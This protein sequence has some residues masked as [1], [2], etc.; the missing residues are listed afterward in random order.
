MEKYDPQKI[1]PKWSRHMGG[2]SPAVAGSTA[3][4]NKY[5]PKIIERKWQDIWEKSGIYKT[6]DFSEKSKFY[7]LDF[8]PYPSGD[9]LHVGHTKGYIATDA[10]SRMKMMQGFNVLHPMGW[11]AFG[12]PAEN[13]AIKHKIH[14]KISTE[15]NISNFKKQDY[16]IG[17]TYDWDREISTIDP[18]FYKWTQWIFLKM[19]EKGLAYESDEPVNWCPSCKTVLANEDLENGACERCGTQVVQKKM[20][21][22]VLKMT[23]YAD[24]L[25]NDL[26]SKDLDWEE[27]IKEQQ[28]NWIGRSE[29]AT[30]KFQI[31]NSKLQKNTK[32]QI[33]NTKYFI[34][35]F[36]TRLDTIF[37]CTYCVV[38]PEHILVASLLDAD[39]RRQNA[40]LRGQVSN[41]KEVEEYV[42]KA[43]NKTNLERTE[44]QKEKTGV[45]L[46]GVKAI[47]P[48]TNEEI[49]VW[50]ADYVLGFY[51]TG[52]VMA[53]P[54]HDE[55]DF[56]F[57]KKYGLSIKESVA[58]YISLSG[59]NEPKS[60]KETTRKN[61]V[62]AILRD[63]KKN[64]YLLLQWKDKFYGF[65]GGAIEK[66]ETPEEAILREI[67]EEIGYKNLKIQEIVVPALFG[68]GYKQRKDKNNFNFDRVYL[69]DIIGDEREN[70]SDKI[71]SEHEI[72]WKSFEEVGKLDLLDHHR[73]MWKRYIDKVKCFTEDGILINSGKYN[74]LASAK[75]REEMTK[76]LE[77]QGIGKKKVNYKMR[78]WVFSRQRYWGEPFPL[79]FCE[80]CKKLVE[81]SKIQIPNSKQNPNTKFQ[82]KNL[83]FNL[84]EILNP[85]WIAVS[86]KD[87]PVRL[88]EVESYEPTG[89]G[90]SPLAK[91]SEW[92]NV[93][94]PKCGEAAKRETNTMPQWA[95]SSWYYLR[96]IDPKNK[97]ALVDKKKEKYWM[98]V[99]LYV[100]GA[101]HATRHLLYARFW[102]KFLY[103][104]GTVSTEE[105]FKRLVHVGLINGE[106]G[107]KMSKRWGNVINPDDVAAQFGADTLRLYEMFMGPFTQNISWSTKSVNGMRRFLERAWSLNTKFQIINTKQIPNSKLQIP[108]KLERL[109][110]KTIKKVTDDIEGFKFNTAISALMVLSNEFS[111]SGGSAL[112]GEKTIP[113]E[114]FEKFLILLSPFA[115]HIA[116]ELW[117]NLG[118]K[119]SI[120]LEAWPKYDAKL[121][122]EEETEMLIQ[123]N[124]KLRDK[125]KT[126][127][128]I[129]E[130]EAKKMALASEKIKKLISGKEIKKVIFVKG[131]LI[132]IVV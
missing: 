53:V 81:N 92:V 52:A 130:D 119:K 19:F 113:K 88:P 66:G 101:E 46:K 76:W 90:E 74:S 121:V 131:R 22:W 13:Y 20:R 59:A 39:R 45:E 110:H 64:Q 94:C 21:Q 107:K 63:P 69:V 57:A 28:R 115:P 12:L 75:A 86:E 23:A 103:D 125:I 26:D 51:G 8:F 106:D 27:L 87:L 84:G 129:S 116:E 89:T 70:L 65:A 100:G 132:N 104:I 43:Q 6:Q 97:K 42:I 29:G 62:T 83:E 3:M 50:T 102:H 71:R 49:P 111:A 1:E 33:P 38:A 5:N 18:E 98:P 54:A 122:K 91:I 14:P 25:L 15:K 72:S 93:K 105:P 77:A 117:Y 10:V 37:G 108:N 41:L 7:A 16:K 79:I 55:R 118:N 99:D 85:G 48:F 40:D 60:D 30:V 34:E 61:V 124:S 126:A 56:E 78:D 95:G 82:I 11:D 36:T 35:V 24:R 9:G 128:D 44:L 4:N 120:F 73:F 96:Y 2:I 32:Y 123:V 17:F 58:P 114:Y 68:H 47:N 31:T 80:H 112:G 67:T 109:L 127:A